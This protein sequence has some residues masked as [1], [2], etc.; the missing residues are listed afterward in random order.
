M[1]FVQQQPT[2]T[3]LQCTTATIAIDENP[4]FLECN[5]FHVCWGYSNG[6]ATCSDGN[7]YTSVSTISMSADLGYFLLD[8]TGSVSEI[9]TSM[10]FP[11]LATSLKVGPR[12]ACALWDS[13][14]TCTGVDAN[15]AAYITAQLNQGQQLALGISTGILLDSGVLSSFQSSTSIYGGDTDIPLLPSVNSV[16]SI[17]IGNASACAISH[18]SAI[19]WGPGIIDDQELLSTMSVSHIEFNSFGGCSS[20]QNTLTCWGA[21]S[22]TSRTIVTPPQVCTGI[23]VNSV[24]LPC[25]FNY[26][27]NA[28]QCVPCPPNFVRGLNS[29]TCSQC[30][31]GF[32]AGNGICIACNGGYRSLSMLSCSSCNDGFQSI[33]G[34]SC[35][36][37]M[38]K[39]IRQ[40]SMTSCSFCPQGSLPINSSQCQ[41]CDS[42]FYLSYSNSALVFT[43]GVCVSCDQGYESVQ[44]ICTPC[45]N[46]S[47]RSHGMATCSLCPDGY[48]PNA[49][50]SLCIQC[51]DGYARNGLT[52]RCWQC[53]HPWFPSSDQSK[54]IQRDY[55]FTSTQ[56]VSLACFLL[57]AIILVL[58]AKVFSA[59]ITTAVVT[60][61]LTSLVFFLVATKQNTSK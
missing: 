38:P 31:E 28:L 48:E 12:L 5:D 29:T 58:F 23:L 35:T 17:A 8:I 10:P 16:S 51:E 30:E 49:S 11:P 21:N 54:C 27:L 19:C 1:C 13:Y 46:S 40:G 32:E 26:E 61:A 36:P 33:D 2:F 25:P 20:F 59:P 52:S 3:A 41:F 34:I 56:S 55:M 57:C 50:H 60:L 6:H 15:E 47:Y 39:M 37:C 4:S 45:R 42:P 9:E 14:L 44:G 43:D 24:C 22:F 18:T 7:S 53:V